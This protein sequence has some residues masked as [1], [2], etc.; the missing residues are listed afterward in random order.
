[1]KPA[2]MAWL[3]FSQLAHP[4][5]ESARPTL[6]RDDASDPGYD[7]YMEPLHS[8]DSVESRMA[9]G[10]M[11]ELAGYSSIAGLDDYF[12]ESLDRIATRWAA[13]VKGM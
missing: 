2:Y 8:A 12:L 13:L 11:F 6:L 5:I 4:T 9:H 1:M 3:N 10:V 7:L